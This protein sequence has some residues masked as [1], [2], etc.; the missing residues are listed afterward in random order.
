MTKRLQEVKTTTWHVDGG[1][2][3]EISDTLYQDNSQI[4]QIQRRQ[5]K[6]SLLGTTESHSHVCVPENKG[7]PPGLKEIKPYPRDE[8][9]KNDPCSKLYLQAQVWHAKFTRAM[10]Q[11]W[12]ERW[13][14][15]GHTSNRTQ[16]RRSNVF[17]RALSEPT[18]PPQ[19]ICTPHYSSSIKP[20]SP[21]REYQTNRNET[22]CN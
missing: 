21:Q 10:N 3:A 7:K 17:N 20:Q 22:L 11:R 18:F 9:V 8:T 5:A 1:T 2:L 15:P 4:C 14:K 6:Q 16:R 19:V 12:K 13:V